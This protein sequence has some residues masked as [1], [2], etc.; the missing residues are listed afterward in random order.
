MFVF[1]NFSIIIHSGFFLFHFVILT[2]TISQLLNHFNLFLG[3]Y[4]SFLILG[5]STITNQKPLFKISFHIKTLSALFI[6][7]VITASCL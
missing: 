5:L 3:M 1:L 6:I 7:L 2:H 4:I